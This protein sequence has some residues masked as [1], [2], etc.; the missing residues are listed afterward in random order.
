MKP[1]KSE[2]ISIVIPFYNIINEAERFKGVKNNLFIYF[3]TYPMAKFVD[4]KRFY[5]YGKYF[6]MMTQTTQQKS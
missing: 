6:F 3:F 4:L 5:F 1:T 2:T